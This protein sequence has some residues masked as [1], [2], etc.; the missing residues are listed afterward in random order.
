MSIGAVTRRIFKDAK[1]VT[2]AVFGKILE[3][4]MSKSWPKWNSV[5]LRGEA[6][7]SAKRTSAYSSSGFEPEVRSTELFRNRYMQY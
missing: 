5:F 1:M 4:C 7:G 3:K 2:V 6:A